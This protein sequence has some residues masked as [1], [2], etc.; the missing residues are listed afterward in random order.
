[1]ISNTIE[2]CAG[3]AGR[4]EGEVHR[5]TSS[6]AENAKSRDGVPEM[7]QRSLHFIFIS[8]GRSQRQRYALN[9]QMCS[10]CIMGTSGGS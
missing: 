7:I 6:P 2:E 8:F 1:M 9:A 4:T 5:R 3:L 10:F